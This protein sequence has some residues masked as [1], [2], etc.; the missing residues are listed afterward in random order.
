M[1]TLGVSLD[2]SSSEGGLYHGL[3]ECVEEDSRRQN[4]VGSKRSELDYRLR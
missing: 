1:M 2:K 3:Q 4:A